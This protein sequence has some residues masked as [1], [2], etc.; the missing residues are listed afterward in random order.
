MIVSTTQKSTVRQGLATAESAHCWPQSSPESSQAGHD[1]HQTYAIGQSEW[2][3]TA[4]AVK[5][6]VTWLWQNTL[7]SDASGQLL[8]S[9]DIERRLHPRPCRSLIGVADLPAMPAPAS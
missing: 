8:V 6:A 9:K 2:Q 7:R 1:Q 3:N 5:A 4:S